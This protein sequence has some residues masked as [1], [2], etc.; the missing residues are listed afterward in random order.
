MTTLLT[1]AFVLGGR[2]VVIYGLVLVM[3]KLMG[4]RE[5]GQLSPLDFVVGVMIG[6][7]AALPMMNVEIPLLPALVPIVV[8]AGLE[9][10]ASVLALNN[11]RIR[12]FVEDKPTIIIRGGSI[13]K[14]NMAKVR[15]NMDDLKQELR[16]HGIADINEVEEGTLESVGTFTI[17]K[18]K[19]N[20]PLTPAD[21]QAAS[22]DNIDLLI[23]AFASKARSDLKTLLD[24]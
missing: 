7:L 3:V 19:Q 23:G 10:L 20:Q 14:E 6:S 9:I 17:I 8:L 5:V 22:M 13:I 12:R 15:L 1:E 18:K 24:R 4:K 21:L 2:T 16:K 11:Y